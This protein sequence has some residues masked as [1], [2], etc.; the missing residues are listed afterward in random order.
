MPRARAFLFCTMQFPK[1]TRVKD[2]RAIELA[3]RDWCEL[4][5]R[6]GAVHVHHIRSRGAGGDD[7]LE[8]L[9]SLC[10]ECHDLVHRGRIPREW[11]YDAKRPGTL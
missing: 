4:C 5:G 8:N 11:L 10:P 9:I 6:P 3:R 1:P 2:R 7:V